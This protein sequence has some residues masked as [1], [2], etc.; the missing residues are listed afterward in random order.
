LPAAKVGANG[1]KG[2]VGSGV[3]AAEAAEYPLVPTP[4]VAAT[5][6]KYVEPLSKPA[7]VHDRTNPKSPQPAAST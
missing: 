5:L 1:R 7:A 3:T 2:I 6:K 4:L